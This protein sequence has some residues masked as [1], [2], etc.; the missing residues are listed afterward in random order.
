[1]AEQSKIW[2]KERVICGMAAF[3]ALASIYAGVEANHLAASEQEAIE[4]QWPGLWGTPAVVNDGWTASNGDGANPPQWI[5]MEDSGRATALAI[6]A[7]GPGGAVS[8]NT[9]GGF[10][11]GAVGQPV[12]ID[13]QG[14]IANTPARTKHWDTDGLVWNPGLKMLTHVT[15]HHAAFIPAQDFQAAGVTGELISNVN[16]NAAQQLSKNPDDQP[17]ST[18]LARAADIPLVADG[19][20]NPAFDEAP[21]LG[22]VAAPAIVGDAQ[23]VWAYAQKFQSNE[24]GRWDVVVRSGYAPLAAVT[25]FQALDRKSDLLNDTAPALFLLGAIFSISSLVAFAVGQAFS[26][27]KIDRQRS[28]IQERLEA[29]RAQNALAPQNAGDGDGLS[30]NQRGQLSDL[31]RLRPRRL[32]GRH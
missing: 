6:L 24:N 19:E 31:E 21:P 4:R 14:Q 15:N 9:W 12:E 27:K 23:V 30:D 17:D 32:P 16:K 20:Q 22:R 2:T 8:G 5:G 10:R 25:A 11:V 18:L 29:Q 1:M 26:P 13:V 7:P 3:A 28:K